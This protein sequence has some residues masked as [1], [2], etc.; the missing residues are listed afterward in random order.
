MGCMTDDIAILNG[1]GQRRDLLSIDDDAAR[2]NGIF[3]DNTARKRF[4]LIQRMSLGMVQLTW[5]HT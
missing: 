1:G 5:K 4:F 2:E 3:L